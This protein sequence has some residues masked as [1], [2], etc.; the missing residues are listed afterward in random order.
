MVGPIGVLRSERKCPRKKRELKRNCIGLISDEREEQRAAEMRP[1]AGRPMKDY[2]LGLL[3]AMLQPRSAPRQG[4]SRARRLQK[5]RCA[6][7]CRCTVS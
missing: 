5:L 1:Q 2:L 7:T 3:T 6:R 4:R